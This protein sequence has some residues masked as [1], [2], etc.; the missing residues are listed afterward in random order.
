MAKKIIKDKNGILEAYTQE[1]LK[2]NEKPKSVHAFC[3]SIKISEKEFY[4]HFTNF[5]QLEESVFTY[6]FEATVK[7]L[8]NSKDY[9]SYDAK[10]KLLSFYYTFFEQLTANRTLVLLLL[11]NGK[12]ALQNLKKL[13]SLRVEFKKYVDGLGI[14]PVDLPKENLEKIQQKS[15]SEMAWLQLMST[16]K[17]WIDDTSAGFE[18]T[19]VFIEKSIQAGFDFLSLEPLKNI[20]DFGK[21]IWQEKVKG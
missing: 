12:P 1:L 13:S 8:S 5:D 19:D 10:T 14:K 18:K 21:F 3:E 2:T 11:E 6:F 7:A 15:I 20:I 16:L 4:E 9:E 17:F